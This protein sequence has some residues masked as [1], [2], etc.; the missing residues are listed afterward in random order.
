MTK[1]IYLRI[2]SIQ[3]IKNEDPIEMDLYTECKYIEKSDATFLVYNETEILGNDSKVV[4]RIDDKSLHMNRYGE[5]G[6]KMRFVEGER[7]TSIYKTPYGEFKIEILTE[8]LQMEIS[9]EKGIIKVEY[10]VSISGSP[11]NKNILEVSY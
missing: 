8:K 9:R 10:T 1:D 3:T 11:E 4:L 5:V 6:S 7:D 2:K